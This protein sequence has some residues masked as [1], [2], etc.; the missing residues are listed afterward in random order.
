MMKILSYLAVF[1]V[2]ALSY[3][4]LFVFAATHLK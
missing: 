1:G 4:Y 3:P 2:G